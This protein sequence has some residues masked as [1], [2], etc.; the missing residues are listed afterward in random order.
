VVV[1]PTTFSKTCASQDVHFQY[2]GKPLH[3]CPSEP[4]N[5]TLTLDNKFSPTHKTLPIKILQL[6][7]TFF[8]LST[9]KKPC[10]NYSSSLFLDKGNIQVLQENSLFH[11]S[12]CPL[13]HSSLPSYFP[14]PV[15]SANGFFSLLQ[16]LDFPLLYIYNVAKQ[17][18]T[19]FR[20]NLY[21]QLGSMW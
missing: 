4:L 14:F 13:N 3:L 19:H 12:S 5:R 15:K 2:P 18:S 6:Q 21:C 16:D 17:D 10:I 11:S 1:T 8:Y 20:I 9:V 7:T